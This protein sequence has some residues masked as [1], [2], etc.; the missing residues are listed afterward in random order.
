VKQRKKRNAIAEAW[1]AYPC[2]MIESP[3][4]RLLSLSAIR[5]MH[6]LEV[7]HMHNGGAENG[8]LIVT[9]DQFVE[10]G[11]NRNAIGPA[12]RELIALGFVEIAEKGCAGNENLRRAH[13]FRLTYVNTK[14]REQPTNDWRKIETVEEA[15]AMAR[16][17]RGETDPRA[18]DLGRRGGRARSQ[19]SKSSQQNHD[20][21]SQQNHDQNSEIPVSKTMTTK[22]SQ[23][24]HDYYLY[25]GGHS[26]SVG[27]PHPDP[28]IPSLPAKLPWTKPVVRELFG[29]EARERR[30]AVDG[31]SHRGGGFASELPK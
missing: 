17:S 23:Q 11:V 28:A 30:S 4:M 18:R 19:K 16:T 31:L 14:K 3:A 7:E 10:W 9:Y 15:E 5:V 21:L 8:R 29:A 1:V 6:R 26:V 12:I 27:P 13:R 22:P 20:W 2:T 25:L 24:N